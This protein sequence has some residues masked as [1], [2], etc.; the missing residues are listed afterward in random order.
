MMAIMTCRA[1]MYRRAQELGMSFTTQQVPVGLG[2][3][4]S[5][6][7]FD[8]VIGKLKDLSADILLMSGD[9]DEGNIVGRTK[10]QKL[11]PGRGEFISRVRGHEMVQICK[12][13]P[14]FD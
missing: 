3:G 7:L 2:G 1:D 10:M 11:P 8:P 12:L 4:A 6:A 14:L 13:P 9:R 5:R